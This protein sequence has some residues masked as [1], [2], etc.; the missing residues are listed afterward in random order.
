MER[1]LVYGVQTEILVICAESTGHL[2]L[3]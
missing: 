3:E 2:E 1:M